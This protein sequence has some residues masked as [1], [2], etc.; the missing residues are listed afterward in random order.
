MAQRL[1]GQSQR[2][3]DLGVLVQAARDPVVVAE[4]ACVYETSR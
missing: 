2:E 3:R 1:V 4:L